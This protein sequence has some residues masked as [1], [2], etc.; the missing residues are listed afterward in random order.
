MINRSDA[1]PGPAGPP[2]SIERRS[3]PRRGRLWE[4]VQEKILRLE[5]HL[6]QERER[7]RINLALGR[8][9]LRT[10]LDARGRVI[11]EFGQ[12]VTRAAVL[13]ARRWSA[14]EALL[15]AVDDAADNPRPS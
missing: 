15:A 2:R 1:G 10:V 8:P 3:R 12:P 14:L 13:R 7:R 11:L 6:A 9:V 5:A 4:Q